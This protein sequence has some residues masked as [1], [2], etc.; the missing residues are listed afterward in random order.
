MKSKI[1]LA[2]GAGFLGRMLQKHFAAKGWEVVVLSR[3]LVGADGAVRFVRWDGEQIG[4]WSRELEGALAL[5]NLAG[6]SVNFRYNARNRRLIMDS[7]LNSTRVL[8]EAIAHCERPPKVWLNSSTATIYEHSVDESMGE[9]NGRIGASEEA[10]DAFS[11]EVA[12]AWEKSFAECNTPRTRKVALRTAMVLGVDAGGVYRVLR[13]LTRLGLGGAMGDGRQYVSWIHA[14]DFCRAI[15][16]LI[17]E[18]ETCGVVNLAAPDP[19]PNRKMMSTLRWVLGVPFGLPAAKWMLE[20]GAFLMRTETELIIKSRRVVPRRLEQEGFR[21]R[22]RHFVE[23]VRAL[24]QELAD[25]VN[26]L[27]LETEVVA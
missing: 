17:T 19:L 26:Q 27:R 10:K 8:G 25:D 15:D 4:E 22:H 24:E 12:M 21:F 14:D 23:A 13:R 20:I 11:V 18:R 5:V 3:R 2:G 6:R 7:R 1:I 16:W 9:W